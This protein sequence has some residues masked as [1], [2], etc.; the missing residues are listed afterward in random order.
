MH[1]M[2]WLNAILFILRNNSINKRCDSIESLNLN[3]RGTPPVSAVR[4]QF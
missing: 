2:K 3:L 4:P 1:K